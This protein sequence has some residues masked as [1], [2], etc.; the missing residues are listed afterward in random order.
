[1]LAGRALGAGEESGRRPDDH[2][3]K[4]TR[5][6]RA[7]MPKGTLRDYRKEGA[8][9]LVADAG[10][11]Y[12]VTAICTHK[13]CTVY[14]QGEDGFHCPCHDSEYDRSGTVTQGPAQ[15]ALRHLAVRESAPGGALEVDV[16]KE[17]A[18]DERF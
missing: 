18:P 12:A 8:F 11:I 10:G 16:G 17:V 1:V 14:A 13:G 5:E 7:T 15:R 2:P 3:V 4:T 9:F 6:T